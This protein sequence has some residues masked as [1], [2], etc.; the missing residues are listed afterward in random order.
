M[1]FEPAKDPAITH[2]EIS[3]NDPKDRVQDLDNPFLS[4]KNLISKHQE[5]SAHTPPF[6]SLAIGKGAKPEPSFK[7]LPAAPFG[8]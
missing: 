8:S 1:T 4:L 2:Q 3:R 6:R 7:E 5:L